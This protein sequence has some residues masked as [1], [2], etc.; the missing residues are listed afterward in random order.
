MKFPPW[1]VRGGSAAKSGRV[2][3]IKPDGTRQ[4][5]GKAKSFPLKKGDR[6]ILETGGGGGW[7]PPGER[8]LELIQRDLD[9][10]YI[11]AEAAE[12]DYGVTIV[13]G[14]AER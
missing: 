5:M 3:V 10:G 6:V 7:G 11:T 14:N 2:T 13:D 9:R 1:G 4:I 8:S 12:K